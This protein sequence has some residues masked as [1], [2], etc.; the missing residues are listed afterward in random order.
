[1][2]HRTN[3]WTDAAV[4]VTTIGAPVGVAVVAVVVAV[5]LAWR[6]HSPRP[7]VVLLGSL[8]TAGACNMWTKF[9]VGRDRPHASAH[10]ITEVGFSYPSGHVA[11][12]AALI[13]AMLLLYLQGSHGRLSRAV[14]VVGAGLAVTAVAASRLY[15]GVH[16][17][18]DVIG[19][20]LLGSAVVLATAMVTH[21]LTARAAA[22][23][24]KAEANRDRYSRIDNNGEFPGDKDSA[25]DS[26]TSRHTAYINADNETAALDDSM[27]SRQ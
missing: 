20:L 4:T 13:G 5:I 16:W 25:R 26:A 15:L 23:A 3:A 14:A 18:T 24:Q 1:M 10:L 9:A 19:G 22:T 17:L 7:A 21:A 12:S 2:V 8:M 27:T 11:G 6:Q